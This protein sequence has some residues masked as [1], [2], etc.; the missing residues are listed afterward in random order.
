M[1]LHL[2]YSKFLIFLVITNQIV[3]LY[4]TP[5][6]SAIPL[7]RNEKFYT[8]CDEPYLDITFNITMR[9]KTLFYTVNIIIPCMGISFLTVL[10]FYLPSDSGEKV[11]EYVMPSYADVEY[12]SYSS[13]YRISNLCCARNGYSKGRGLEVWNA[14]NLVVHCILS[15]RK[16]NIIGVFN[17]TIGSKIRKRI[18]GKISFRIRINNR[19]CPGPPL[20][21]K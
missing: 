9:R 11:S 10:T 21:P 20:L 18:L 19:I 8:C 1:L 4:S 3:H 6:P 12:L 17:G 16:Q 5:A 14:A 15:N 2:S 13:E 7:R